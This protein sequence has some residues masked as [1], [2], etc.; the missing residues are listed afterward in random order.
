MHNKISFKILFESGHHNT[1]VGPL[2]NV[3]TNN[4]K[5]TLVTLDQ[6]LQF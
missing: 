6:H 1:S 5:T 3:E 2:S 4:T